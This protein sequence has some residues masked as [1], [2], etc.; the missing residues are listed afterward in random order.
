MELKDPSKWMTVKKLI[1]KLTKAVESG[2]LK[3]NSVVIGCADEFDY[4]YPISE[5]SSLAYDLSEDIKQCEH[6]VEYYRNKMSGDEP[7]K[8]KERQVERLKT[9]NENGCCWLRGE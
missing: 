5:D 7:R 3:E 1:D 8:A 6:M 2:E 4:F 9:L